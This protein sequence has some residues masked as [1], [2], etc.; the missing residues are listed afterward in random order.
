MKERRKKKRQERKEEKSFLLRTYIK[1]EGK[2]E[3]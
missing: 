3:H 1:D 2:L